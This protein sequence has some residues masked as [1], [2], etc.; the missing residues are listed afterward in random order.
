MSYLMTSNILYGN[1]AIFFLKIT[2]IMKR[3]CKDYQ[4]GENAKTKMLQ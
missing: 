3:L 4:F 1:K 2:W